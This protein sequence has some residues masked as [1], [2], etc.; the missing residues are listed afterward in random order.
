VKATEL[1]VP[2]G[3]AA[4]SISQGLRCEIRNERTLADAM[5][6]MSEKESNLLPM[7][8]MLAQ[9]IVKN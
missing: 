8:L 4:I 7:Y 5:K 2:V 9:K 3:R 1:P 6:L